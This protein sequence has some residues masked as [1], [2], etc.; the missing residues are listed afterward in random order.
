MNKTIRNLAAAF[1][2]VAIV[3]MTP[4][5]ASAED[6]TPAGDLHAFAVQGAGCED[7]GYIHINAARGVEWSIGGE[8]VEVEAPSSQ[9]PYPDGVQDDVTATALP[10]YAIDPGVRSTFYLTVNA[11]QCEAPKQEQP[12]TQ[13]CDPV[14][15]RVEDTTRVAILERRIAAKNERIARLRDRIA[16]LRNR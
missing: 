6:V 14:V 5:P 4:S 13:E 8:S 1:G 9:F 10:G 11:V 15:Q 7:P 3:T 2:L 16:A 12:A